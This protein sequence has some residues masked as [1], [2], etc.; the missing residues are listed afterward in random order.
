MA[1][2]L[3]KLIIK[4]Q[5]K[6]TF[7]KQNLKRNPL[8]IIYNSELKIITKILTIISVFKL[9]KPSFWFTYSI[10]SALKKKSPGESLR[11]EKKIFFLF[12]SLFAKALK[13]TFSLHIIYIKKPCND[14]K[15]NEDDRRG[16]KG[17]Y[18]VKDYKF[19]ACMKCK[20]LYSIY[21]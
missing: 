10:P 6:S 12:F 9:I 18:G 8:K 16:E 4:L 1:T 14:N 13:M 20:L 3:W 5:S 21:I 17:L 15:W 2:K 11:P 19:G 7:R